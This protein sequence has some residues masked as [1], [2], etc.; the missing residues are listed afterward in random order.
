MHFL[1]RALFEP[2]GV[3]I[4]RPV[5]RADE[6]TIIFVLWARTVVL[7]TVSIDQGVSSRLVPEKCPLSL[8]AS[9]APYNTAL[10]YHAE[11]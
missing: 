9:T 1:M 3:K 4:G 7:Y 2:S 10:R 8:K 11:M 6:A 5:R